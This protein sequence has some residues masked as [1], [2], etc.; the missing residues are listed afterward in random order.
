MLR[1]FNLWLSIGWLMAIMLCYFS[2]IS[3]PP[4][5]DI[6]FKSFDKV[7][8]LLAYFIL[9]FWFAQ[10]YKE[11]N[12]RIYYALFF[13]A[14]GIVLEVFQGLGGVRYFEYY[15]MLANTIGVVIAL[16]ITKNKWN[17]V[18]YSIEK[19]FYRYGN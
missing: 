2:L 13:I 3:N 11:N 7:R 8:H 6:G 15:D 16:L 1:Y 19:L 17:D 9:M 10:L 12:K 18:L 4:E 5:F 14:M